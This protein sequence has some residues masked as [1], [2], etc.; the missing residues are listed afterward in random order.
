MYADVVTRSM[1]IC[2]EETLRRRRVQTEYNVEHGITP[3]SIA[4]RILALEVPE[5][6]DDK[7]RKRERSEA[8]PAPVALEVL[9]PEVLEQRIVETRAAMTAAARDLEFERAAELRDTL[10]RYEQQALGLAP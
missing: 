8:K 7:R 1:N 4:S 6:A 3:T 10:R 2:I 5:A 9:R